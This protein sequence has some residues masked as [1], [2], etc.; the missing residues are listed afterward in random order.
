MH[1][2]K[3]ASTVLAPIAYNRACLTAQKVQCVTTS[4][5][6]Q[7]GEDRHAEAYIGVSHI[8]YI[9]FVYMTGHASS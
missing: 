1:E 3:A 9:A 2:L 8:S 6:V 4:P 5:A 7:D